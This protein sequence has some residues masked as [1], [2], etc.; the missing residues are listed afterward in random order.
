MNKKKK[1]IIIV[2]A[3]LV[4]LIVTGV[5]LYVFLSVVPEKK[6]QEERARLVKEYYNAK[7]IRYEEE[8]ERYADFEVDVAFLGDSLTDGYDLERYYPQ[9]L[10]ANRGIGGETTIGLE[11]RMQVSVYDLQPKVAVMLIG[12][13][14]LNTMFDNYER[15]LQGMK[16][17]LPNTEIVLL[18]LTALGRDWARKNELCT[19]NNVRIKKLAEKYRYR[20]VDLFT[21]LFDL[22]ANE[23]KPEYTVDGAHFTPE[24]YEVVTAQVTPVLKEILGR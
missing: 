8:N 6:K 16:E 18:S 3:C 22:D 1:I 2:A 4:A 7:R 15:I 11:Q 19:Y 5:L 9:Y 17:N 13:N 12:G 23:L 24:G 10:T 20:Y 21:P 14:N